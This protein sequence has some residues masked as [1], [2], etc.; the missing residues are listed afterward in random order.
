MQYLTIEEVLRLH[1]RVI[2]QTGGSTGI[3]DRGAL[4]SAIAQPLMSFGGEELYPTLAD[5]AAAF[6]FSLTMNH[7]FVDGNKRTA[8]AAMEVFLV[9][10]G[11]EIHA[12]VDD[13]ESVMLALAAGTL[14]REMFT[15]WLH[16]HVGLKK[17]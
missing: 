6:G 4:E 2:E 8:H 9:L 12:T 17:R 10:N 3:R 14:N 7:P 16:Q 11:L 5:K 13:Q 15:Q 1:D